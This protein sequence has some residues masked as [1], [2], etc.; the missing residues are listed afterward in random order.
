MSIENESLIASVRAAVGNSAIDIASVT[1]EMLQATFPAACAALISAA[2]VTERKRVAG[3]QECAFPG[4]GA[5]VA[6]LIGSGASL[7]DAALRLNQAERALAAGRLTAIKDA[8]VLLAGI[9]VAPQTGLRGTEAE[10]AQ[11]STEVV[12]TP[13]TW[14]KEYA[15]SPKLRAEFASADDYVSLMKAGNRARIFGGKK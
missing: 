3:I 10:G 1:G 15:A 14:A 4:Q 8:D 2:A 6:E 9:T 5:L 11:A 7:G 13:E 12:G